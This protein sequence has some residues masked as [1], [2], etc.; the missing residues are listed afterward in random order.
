MGMLN[1]LGTQWYTR[2][3]DCLRIHSN[4]YSEFP[5]CTFASCGTWAYLCLE[6]T[7]DLSR[8]TLYKKPLRCS[9][10]QKTLFLGLFRH[11]HNLARRWD[12]K[13][14]RLSSSEP[15]WGRRKT[16][17]TN[18]KVLG[19]RKR[20]MILISCNIAVVE[21]R[22]SAS[23]GIAGR[24]S[25]RAAYAVQLQCLKSLLNKQGQRH[26]LLR[27]AARKVLQNG[28]LT[29]SMMIENNPT[30]DSIFVD[31]VYTLTQHVIQQVKMSHTKFE[32]ERT[33]TQNVIP[34]S[35][36]SIFKALGVYTR[37]IVACPLECCKCSLHAVF[38]DAWS[39]FIQRERTL[40]GVGILGQALCRPATQIWIC[41]ITR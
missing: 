17:I 12:P 37:A 1:T 8:I 36:C 40:L 33:I 38:W 39:I 28:G 9:D 24:S 4:F 14:L 32:V 6:V 13:A 7:T 41:S 3:R 22:N 30:L 35:S 2:I 34:D 11:L 10:L 15:N 19:L 5:I 16:K 29:D 26:A 20:A 23:A 25:I 21:I 18:K 31:M 27:Y